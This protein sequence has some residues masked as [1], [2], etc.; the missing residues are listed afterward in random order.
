M[1]DL[2]LD[3]ESG[4]ML[5]VR[6]G[7][8]SDNLKFHPTQ[9]NNCSPTERPPHGPLSSKKLLTDS[10]KRTMNQ[11][12]LIL[13]EVPTLSGQEAI[14]RQIRTAGTNGGTARSPPLLRRITLFDGRLGEAKV[15]SE[16]WEY[17]TS[18]FTPQQGSANVL[19]NATV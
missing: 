9:S 19:A 12:R 16:I 6:H 4:G 18:L 7:R 8:T 13:T 1:E 10:A 15:E 5:I 17:I 2:R 3:G 14:S 11:S